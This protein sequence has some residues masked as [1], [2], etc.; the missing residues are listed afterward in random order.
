MKGLVMTPELAEDQKMVSVEFAN[1]PKVYSKRL[2]TLQKDTDSIN[3]VVN[4]GIVK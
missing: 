1:D 4:G 2:Q 3:P